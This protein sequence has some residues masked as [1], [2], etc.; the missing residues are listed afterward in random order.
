VRRA[1]IERYEQLLA[2]ALSEKTRS[3]VE[4]LLLEKN[5][6]IVEKRRREIDAWRRRADELRA[7][8]DQFK[9]PSAQERLRRIAANLNGVADHA[10]ALLT[11]KPRAPGEKT[12]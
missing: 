4:T 11:G 10:E 6:A 2:A 7:T 9:V 1:N 5:E 12:V 8:A 3:T